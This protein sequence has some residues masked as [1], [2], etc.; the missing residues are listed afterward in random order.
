MEIKVRALDGIEEK[1][2]QEVEQALLE[3]HEKG[4]SV[5]QNTARYNIGLRRTPE[6]QD[7]ILTAFVIP[8][9]RIYTPF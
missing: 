7:N 2:V 6:N 4:S 9:R 1:S 8:L 5:L 3:K